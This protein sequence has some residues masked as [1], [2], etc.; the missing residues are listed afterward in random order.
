MTK[1]R[2]E[3]RLA[4]VVAIR[5][6]EDTKQTLMREA[7]TRGKTLSEHLFNL[8]EAGREA[9]QAKAREAEPVSVEDLNDL[10]SR[11]AEAE[12]AAE[13]KEIPIVE[14]ERSEESQTAERVV[15][16][17]HQAEKIEPPPAAELPVDEPFLQ[18]LK[19]KY[20]ALDFQKQMARVDQ[21]AKRNPGKKVSRGLLN[22]L[23][24]AAN[25]MRFS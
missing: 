19:E 13:A 21:W 11:A 18:S 7:T 22:G 16:P 15:E 4:A 12:V 20:P 8:I 25:R 6:P 23:F 14:G 5:L 9:M 1:R 10:S 3:E 2:P 17:Q 24:E